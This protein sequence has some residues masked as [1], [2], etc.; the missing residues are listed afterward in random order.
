[1]YI[2]V[3]HEIRY[4]Y[5]GQVYIEPMT[6]RLRPRTDCSQALLHYQLTVDPKPQG[7]SES[8]DL[9]GN[10]VTCIWSPGLCTSLTLKV[11][12]LV[13]TKREN[14]FDFILTDDTLFSLPAKYAPYYHNALDPYLERDYTGDDVVDFAHELIKKF[15]AN[16]VSFLSQTNLYIHENFE[17]EIRDSGDPLN[18][19]ELLER[20]K[21]ACRDFAVLFMDVCRVL[22]LAA[23]FTSGYFLGET[24]EPEYQLHA[25]AEVYLPGAGWR[26]YDPTHGLAVADRHIALATGSKPEHAAPTAGMYRGTGITSTLEYHIHLHQVESPDAVLQSENKV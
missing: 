10:S 3:Q 21:G 16:T 4:I 7:M 22:G 15:G 20:K 18:P 26:G 6:I 5:S 13:E 14:P 8:V 25:W 1:M 11:E 12:S 9:D 19:S 23:R 17:R 24:E 2:Q